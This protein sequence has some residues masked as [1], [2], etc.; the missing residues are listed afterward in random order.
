VW[1]LKSRMLKRDEDKRQMSS[2]YGHGFLSIF[3]G[4]K[5]DLI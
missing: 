4:G 1:Y 2:Q 3:F 5:Y